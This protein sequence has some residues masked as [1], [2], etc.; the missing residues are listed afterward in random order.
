MRLRPRRSDAMLLWPASARGRFSLF[1]RAREV[2][3]LRMNPPVSLDCP[4]WARAGF[5]GAGT[6]PC[7]RGPLYPGSASPQWLIPNVEKLEWPG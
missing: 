7:Q 1:L 4:A 3:P 2:A 5:R 6:P